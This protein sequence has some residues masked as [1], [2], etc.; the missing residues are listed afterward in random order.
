MSL[1]SRF[2]VLVSGSSTPGSAGSGICL[3]HTT[4]IM[5]PSLPDD[6][7]N[8]TNRGWGFHDGR[9][10]PA[11][12]P[13]SESRRHRRV[14]AV[15]DNE[16]SASSPPQPLSDQWMRGFPPPPEVRLSFHDGSFYGWPQLRWT[17][18]NIGQLVPTRTAWRGP[19]A[20][21]V[22][23]G[24]ATTDDGSD[25]PHLDSRPGNPPLEPHRPRLPTPDGRHHRDGLITRHPITR[26]LRTCR[27][28][29]SRPW[30][31]P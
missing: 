28:P 13:P 17:F 7:G 27:L 6:E 11:G 12:P 2:R 9:R 22:L 25:G 18:S 20:A 23:D 29:A 5:G 10:S 26:L 15:S 14:V 30:C 19:G 31:R 24:Q 4:T 21:R 1:T 3:T 8:G 16:P